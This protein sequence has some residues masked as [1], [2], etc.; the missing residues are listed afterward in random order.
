M[1]NSTGEGLNTKYHRYHRG[2]T[3]VA[4]APLH[5]DGSRMHPLPRERDGP[6]RALQAATD[7]RKARR[8]VPPAGCVGAALNGAAA[9]RGTSILCLSP[10]PQAA[11]VPGAHAAL[12]GDDAAE[13]VLWLRC[14]LA[15]R[16]LMQRGVEDDGGG[17]ATTDHR[18]RQDG[19]LLALLRVSSS[20]SLRWLLPRLAAA[21]AARGTALL[22]LSADQPLGAGA[23][24]RGVPDR[25]GGA[26]ASCQ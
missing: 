26:A 9:A 2:G 11:R 13:R 3:I 20:A 22:L 25:S 16:R 12:V 4:A 17:S 23:R 6:Q 1:V 19:W 8:A 5:A 14:S 21:V 15:E 10:S 18:R 24:R 7:D